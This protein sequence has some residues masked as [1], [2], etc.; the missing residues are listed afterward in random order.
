VLRLGPF[1][2]IEDLRRLLARYCFDDVGRTGDLPVAAEAVERLWSVSRGQP[3]L[4]QMVAGRSFGRAAAQQAVGVAAGHVEEAY[5]ELLAEKPQCF[6]EEQA[7][8]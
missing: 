2:G 6:A 7:G 1:A 4:I 5:R 8:A 3:F